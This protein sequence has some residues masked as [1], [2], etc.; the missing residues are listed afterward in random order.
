MS[1]NRRSLLRSMAILPAACYV[2]GRRMLWAQGA[3]GCQS[4]TSVFVLLEGPWVLSQQN[5]S[6][7]AFTT[8]DSKNHT[9]A[10]ELWTCAN[11]K[12]VWTDLA[13]GTPVALSGSFQTTDYGT[14]VTNAFNTNQ[15]VNPD[16]KDNFAWVPG[17]TVTA[18][19][20]SRQL[21]LP[22]PSGMHT[23]GFLFYADVHSKGS[24]KVLKAESIRAHITTILEYAQTDPTHPASMTYAPPSG[25]QTVA[26]GQHL[27]F[28][29]EHTT[30]GDE[31]K[32]IMKVFDD[33]QRNITVSS[34]SDLTEL[35]IATD[36]SYNLGNDTAG[37]SSS[38]LGF[39]DLLAHT[40]TTAAAKATQ[41]KSGVAHP[42]DTTYA[43]CAGGGIIV[44]P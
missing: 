43:N 14:L 28:R 30:M 36:A 19:S 16:P 42:A 5:G 13:G 39:D 40:S 32:H 21:T 29:L 38:E 22:M 26:P 12:A 15:R 7:N 1:I 2:G 44:G 17:A 37:F 33:N 3:Q 23:A 35:K 18:P 25:N 11:K 24:K 8:G 34:S 9:C 20:S 31:L 4:P 10:V 41:K 27:I 6:L